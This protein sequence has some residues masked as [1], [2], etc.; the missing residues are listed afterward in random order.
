MS[1]QTWLRFLWMHRRP[2]WGH[3][4]L[5]Q[6]RAL[7]LTPLTRWSPPGSRET[8]HR[9]GEQ[10]R[11][12]RRRSPACRQRSQT[13]SPCCDRGSKG[14]QEP[15]G[16]IQG[17]RGPP[18]HLNR[19]S[20][21]PHSSL[22]PW[23]SALPGAPP[24][25]QAPSWNWR[26]AGIAGPLCFLQYSQPGLPGRGGFSTP[27]PCPCCLAVGTPSCWCK[28]VTQTWLVSLVQG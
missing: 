1:L 27:S 14:T 28:P 23:L 2:W 13:Q 20:S 16:G 12:P 22:L 10:G 7:P 3:Q 11:P 5:W 24:L 25:A 19:L 26:G 4:A 8:L 15:P 18:D 9:E 17:V 21:H 6:G